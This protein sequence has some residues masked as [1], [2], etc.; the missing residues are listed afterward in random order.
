MSGCAQSA[1]TDFVSYL[2]NRLQLA[3]VANPALLC[4]S[5]LE[6]IPSLERL[7]RPRARNATHRGPTELCLEGEVSPTNGWLVS[8]PVGRGF[9][10]MFPTHFWQMRYFN[11]HPQSACLLKNF[12]EM[13][14]FSSIKSQ[15][16]RFNRPHF[17]QSGRDSSRSLCNAAPGLYTYAVLRALVDLRKVEV[18]NTHVHLVGSTEELP[19]CRLWVG[20][21]PNPEMARDF[22]T[23]EKMGR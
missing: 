18:S 2:I 20:C 3:L 17:I 14:Y 5:L 13:S 11:Q 4:A 23:V 7:S 22:P 6:C 21:Q 8:D 10:L 9:P 15:A 16:T 19:C 1:Y 12:Q